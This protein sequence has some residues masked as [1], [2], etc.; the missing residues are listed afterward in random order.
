MYTNRWSHGKRIIA[1]SRKNSGEKIGEKKYEWK[2]R[3]EEGG[4][5][6]VRKSMKEQNI[7]TNRWCHGKRMIETRRTNSGENSRLR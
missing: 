5:K 7:T 4:K 3:K 2:G 1:T 6:G